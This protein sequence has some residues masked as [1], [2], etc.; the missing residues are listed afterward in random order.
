MKRFAEWM[1]GKTGKELANYAMVENLDAFVNG[2]KFITGFFFVCSI[3]AFFGIS[4]LNIKIPK[5]VLIVAMVVF[6][7]PFFLTLLYT[8]FK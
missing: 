8:H 3:V 6:G 7:L 1:T 4:K 5:W 2:T